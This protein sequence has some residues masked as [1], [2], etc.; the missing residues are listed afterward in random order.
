MTNPNLATPISHIA[1]L[2]DLRAILRANGQDLGPFCGAFPRQALNT[3]FQRLRIKR[4]RLTVT[5]FRN[6]TAPKQT[7]NPI[8]K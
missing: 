1:T 3:Q 2:E 5:G 8:A 6:H 4:P 7:L